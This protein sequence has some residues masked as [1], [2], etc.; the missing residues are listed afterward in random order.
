M[1]SEQSYEVNGKGC[2]LANAGVSMFWG[3]LEER[4]PLKWS[5]TAGL[6]HGVPVLKM[7]L[8]WGWTTASLE[9]TMWLINQIILQTKITYFSNCFDLALLGEH[10]GNFKEKN[11]LIQW[12]LN[13]SSANWELAEFVLLIV[14]MNVFVLTIFTLVS[15]YAYFGVL[16]ICNQKGKWWKNLHIWRYGEVTLVYMWFNLNFTEQSGLLCVLSN[17]PCTSTLAIE[18]R[19]TGTITIYLQGER[20]YIYSHILLLSW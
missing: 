20:M 13:S 3:S 18:E 8:A 2:L 7:N 15:R 10:E 16:K 9:D 11:S 6:W 17:I 19:N 14:F 12:I 5:L 1:S 4:N